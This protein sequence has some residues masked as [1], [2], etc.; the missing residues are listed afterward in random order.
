M[1]FYNFLLSTKLNFGYGD[2]NGQ[3]GLY[4]VLERMKSIHSELFSIH[5]N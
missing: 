3:S 1:F 2:K 4:I 5:S